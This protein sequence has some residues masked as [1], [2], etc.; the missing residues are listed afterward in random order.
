MRGAVRR[1]H[2]LEVELGR[3]ELA[4]VVG[5]HGDRCV[6]RRADGDKAR[7]R[8]GDAVAMAHPY[9][10]ALPDLPYAVIERRRLCHFDFGAAEFAM[11]PAFDLAAELL[12]HGLLAVADAEHG[13][14]GLVDRHRRQRRVPVEHGCGPAGQ[15]DALRLHRIERRFGFLERHDLA[16]DPL[17]AHAP[18]DE[19]G[20]LRAE[21]DDENLVVSRHG[22][23]YGNRLALS[24][25]HCGSH[26]ARRN[27]LTKKPSVS[28]RRGVISKPSSEI[29]AAWVKR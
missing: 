21:I 11:V 19:L 15:D 22:R 25:F 29:S 13:H 6:R 27:R 23:F 24:S 9:R 4:L 12:R 8:L 28:V 14:A 18:G 26:A 17:L 2:D 16:I 5:D 7:G 3:V 20:D 1:V 10:I